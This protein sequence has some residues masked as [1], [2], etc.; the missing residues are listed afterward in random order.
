MPNL[1]Q[2][3]VNKLSV[4]FGPDTTQWRPAV[5]KSQEFVRMANMLSV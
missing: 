5:E 2:D 1:T 3:A 4:I